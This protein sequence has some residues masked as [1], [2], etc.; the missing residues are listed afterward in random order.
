M[1]KMYVCNLHF[2][3]KTNEASR[4]A[5][6]NVFTVQ[7][8]FLVSARKMSAIFLMAGCETA[9]EITSRQNCTTMRAFPSLP[10][11][12]GKKAKNGTK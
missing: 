4:S 5:S 7:V 8:V 1:K 2:A 11:R 9:F 6:F 12:N 3:I 10:E